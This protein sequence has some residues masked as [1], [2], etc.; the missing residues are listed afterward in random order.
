MYAMIL[1]CEKKNKIKN[2]DEIMSNVS[3]LPLSM[4]ELYK[5]STASLTQA[6]MVG[7]NA[8]KGV[9]TNIFLPVRCILEINI[10]AMPDKIIVIPKKNIFVSIL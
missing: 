3:T 6:H 5:N 7:S 8:S 1:D 10:N 2:A 4:E 9:G